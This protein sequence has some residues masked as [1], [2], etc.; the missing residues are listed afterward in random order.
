MINAKNAGYLQ[1][2]NRKPRIRQKEGVE[3]L[4]IKTAFDKYGWVRRQIRQKPDLGYFVWVKKSID[5]ELVSCMMI[6]SKNQKQRVNNLM[7]IEPG[8]KT[9]VLG[10]CQTKTTGL[11]GVHEGEV[12]I[13]LK[14]GSSLRLKHGHHWSKTDKVK[15]KLRI[16]VGEGASLIKEYKCV[17]TPK[18][19]DIV[20]KI[21]VEKKA[22]VNL[23][24]IILAKNGKVSLKELGELTGDRAEAVIRLRLVA[25]EN[26]QIKAESMMRARGKSVGHVDCMGLVAGDEARIKVVPG[27]LNMDKFSSLTHE[28][29]VGRIEKEK[30]DYLRTRGLSKQQAIDLIVSGFLEIDGKI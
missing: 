22:K 18:D 1:I 23:K 19:L 29:S 8:V 16:K 11:K 10:V 28:A 4:P 15:M 26:S 9:Q 17:K 13:I 30:L 24:T 6:C 3:I 7:I 25:T 27:L 12:L 20:T 2:D 14:K 5:Q 21:R